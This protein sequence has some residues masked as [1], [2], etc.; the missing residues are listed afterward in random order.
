MSLKGV[1]QLKEFVIRYSDMDGSSIGVREWMKINLVTLA[2]NNPD[3]SIRTELKR[4]CHPFFR[5]NYQNGNTKTIG[6]KNQSVED[7]QMYCLDLRNQ[8]G[9]RNGTNGY[10]RPIVTEKPSIQ[11]EWHERLDLIGL[12]FEVSH[13]K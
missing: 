6:I 13:H 10:R 3:L 7:V 9:R 8:I 4:A 5:G 12:K 11:G 2:Q 1:R